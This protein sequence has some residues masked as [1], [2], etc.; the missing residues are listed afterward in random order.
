MYFAFSIGFL[1]FACTYDYILVSI[2]TLTFD[3]SI[4]F[5]YVQVLGLDSFLPSYPLF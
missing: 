5:F 2:C 3:I 4:P 1:D